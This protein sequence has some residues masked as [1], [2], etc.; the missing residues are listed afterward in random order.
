MA[1][2]NVDDERELMVST[3]YFN[4]MANVVAHTFAP[5]QSMHAAHVRMN[6]HWSMAKCKG[7]NRG[8]LPVSGE[9]E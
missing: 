1:K 2:A 4:T 7:T 6:Q 5:A 8:M 3:Q 9:S